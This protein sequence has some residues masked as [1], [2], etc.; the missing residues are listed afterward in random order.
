MNAGVAVLLLPA[1]AAGTVL[2]QTL[3]KRGVQ[4][5]GGIEASH[6]LRPI[7][8]VLRMV[9]SPS[10]VLGFAL[11]LIIALL[12]LMVISRLDLSFA[13]AVLGASYY[14]L[15]GLSSWLVLGEQPSTQR[16]LGLGTI[17]LG[18]FLVARS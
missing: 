9:Q 3:L 15:L 4:H 13:G 14:L 2:S 12:W 16:L 6:L 5:I 11:A 17:G 7:D 18:V 8:L 10:L 1:V